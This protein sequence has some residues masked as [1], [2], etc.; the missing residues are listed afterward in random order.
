MTIAQQILT[1]IFVIRSKQ[2]LMIIILD[3]TSLVLICYLTLTTVLSIYSVTVRKME[4][5]P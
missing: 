5:P 4:K 2:R 3:V 1:P